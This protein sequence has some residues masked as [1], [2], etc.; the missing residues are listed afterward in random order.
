MSVAKQL[1]VANDA[2]FVLG[3]DPVAAAC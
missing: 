1:A 2:L 3:A